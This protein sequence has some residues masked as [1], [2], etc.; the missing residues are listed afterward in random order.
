MMQP[1]AA[2]RTS[3]VERMAANEEEELED[4]EALSV[5]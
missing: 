3:E 1:R 5:T 4:Y 2:D